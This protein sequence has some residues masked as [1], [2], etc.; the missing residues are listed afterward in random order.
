MKIVSFLAILFCSIIANGQKDIFINT[1]RPMLKRLNFDLFSKPSEIGFNELDYQ[2]DQ[3]ILG[4]VKIYFYDSDTICF[5]IN[6]NLP[7]MVTGLTNLKSSKIVISKI[8]KTNYNPIDSIWTY[9]VQYFDE[10]SL[11]L[12]TEKTTIHVPNNS[13]EFKLSEL[14]DE[15]HSLIHFQQ[16]DSQVNL[17]IKKPNKDYTLIS[18][19]SALRQIIGNLIINAFKF[20]KEGE[21][22][23]EINISDT[24]FACTVRDTGI[25]LTHEELQHIFEPFYQASSGRTRQYGGSGLGLSIVNRITSDLGG[26][27]DVKSKKNNFT[28]F[29]IMIPNIVKLKG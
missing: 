27:I 2:I 17:K 18:D 8:P 24:N 4:R 11:D 16:Q 23:F 26:Q 21:I 1:G 7:I 25:G 6:R 13:E 9:T 20:C 15:I 14:I 22:K 28:Q 3:V 19:K 12:S 10:D 29:D 5:R